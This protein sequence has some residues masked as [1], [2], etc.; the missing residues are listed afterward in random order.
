MPLPIVAFR[1]DV[2][3]WV[4]END[5][6]E[7]YMADGSF[8]DDISLAVKYETEEAADDVIEDKELDDCFSNEMN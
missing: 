1:K 3:M 6:G 2:S 5:N 7:Y 4:I 8:T